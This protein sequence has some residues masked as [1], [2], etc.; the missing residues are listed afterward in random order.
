M[1]KQQIAVR[2]SLKRIGI[3][4]TLDKFLYRLILQKSL[5]LVQEAGI[6]LG[7][8]YNWYLY[9][10]YCSNLAKDLFAIDDEIRISKEDESD[11]WKLDEPSTNILNRIKPLFDIDDKS[12]LAKK[13]ELFASLHFLVVRKKMDRQDIQS[14]KHTLKDFGK[15]FEE[16]E[17]TGALKELQDYGILP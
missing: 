9:G 12:Q 14:L 10:P 1:D 3:E 2:L 17:I 5:Y 4:C 15:D 13:L 8:Y 11:K 16:S 6:Q 7:Y